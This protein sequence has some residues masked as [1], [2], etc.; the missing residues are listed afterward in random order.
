MTKVEIEAQERQSVTAGASNMLLRG[1]TVLEAVARSSSRRGIGVTE[2]AVETA[3]DK[4]TASRILAFLRD[5]GYIRQDGY[6]RYR[7]T[8]KL[9]QL[10]AGYSDI[11]DLI[12]VARPHLEELH[13][14]FDEEVYLAVLDGGHM[15]FVD[16]IASTRVVRSTLSKSQRLVHDTAAGRA[17]L[18]LL[19]PEDRLRALALSAA[20]ADIE[21]SA[22]ELVTIQRELDDAR[23][24]GWAGHDAGDE[25]TRF[26]A[27]I[28]DSSGA[29]LAAMCIS[30]P[31][32]RVGPRAAEFSA[33]V[34]RA[35]RQTSA[36]FE[37]SP[38][39]SADSKP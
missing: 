3:L 8:S 30:G 9:S 24:R 1:L 17:A 27:P 25:V 21:F 36:E 16:Y 7:L 31:T 11:E 35:A 28:V 34:V 26:A 10:S 6:R 22:S 19:G 32:F 33:A 2:I 13:T 38:A 5:A 29:P 14:E 4:S 18:A 20:A 12:L 37:K 39:P 23:D 15:H